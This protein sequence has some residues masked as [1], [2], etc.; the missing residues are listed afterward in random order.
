MALIDCPECS[1]RISDQSLACPSCGFPTSE[2]EA[3]INCPECHSSINNKSQSCHECGFPIAKKVLPK[4]VPDYVPKRRTQQ[5]KKDNE[6]G[7]QSLIFIIFIAFVLYQLS[8]CSSD[9]ENIRQVEVSAPDT[10][11]TS[12][13]MS[14]SFE[15]GRYF[16]TSQSTG[17]SIEYIEYIR[18]GNDNTSY[19]KM[20]IKCSNNKVKKYSADNPEALQSA[21]MGNW[22]TPIREGTDQDIVNFI[23]R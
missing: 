2:F 13:P 16:L 6:Y 22:S 7:F 21:D 4:S 9:N 1:N 17:N 3:T 23:C 12:I 11:L 10:N 14:D 20:Q 5:K 19:A 18:K 8:T 15:N